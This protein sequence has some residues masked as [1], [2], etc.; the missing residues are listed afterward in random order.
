MGLIH[1]D[2][3]EACGRNRR[4]DFISL[5]EV[6]RG[7]YLVLSE[8][9]VFPIE[10]IQNSSIDYHKPLF[11]SLCHLAA[12]LVLEM[13][14]RHD[15]N[16]P[17]QMAQLQLLNDKPCH[18]SFACAGVISNEETNPWELQNMSINCFY[19]VRQRI[20]F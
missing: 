18:D 13:S 9:H 6:N 2:K 17:H 12:P 20:H 16:S 14:G 7:N 19:L 1:N 3:V 11:K 4:K 5:G 10:S 15:K 8:P